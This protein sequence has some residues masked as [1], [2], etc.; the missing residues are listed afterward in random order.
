M[1][2]LVREIMVSVLAFLSVVAIGASILVSRMQKRK[3]VEIRLK[4]NIETKA[5]E[6]VSHKRLGI[7]EFLQ[8]V[9]NVVSHGHPST[10]LYEQLIRAGYLGTAAPAIYT[11]IKMLM[12]V[13]G[14]VGTAILVIPVETYFTTKVTLAFLGG[15]VFFFVPNVIVMMQLRK[16]HE[17][18]RRHLPEAIDLLEICVSSGIGLDMAWNIVADEVQ[19]VSP[20]L[21]NAMALTNFEIHLGVGRAEAMRHMAV[22]TAVDELSSLAALLTQTERFGTS[23]ADTLR[24]FATSMRDERSSTMEESA[25]K[26]AVKLLFPMI[27]FI[28]PAVLITAVGPAAITIAEEMF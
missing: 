3:I 26:L 4:D 20:V 14:L 22:R 25:E 6:T 19:H 11:G 17:E 27:L 1:S 15:T 23:I 10:S 21:A 16:R 12:F 5:G 7:L 28:F 8:K 9:G 13:I 24:V 2:I 18:V